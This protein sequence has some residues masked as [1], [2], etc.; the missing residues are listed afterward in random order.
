MVEEDIE[1]IEREKDKK[2]RKER[3]REDG[4]EVHVGE[5]KGQEGD[6][7]ALQRKRGLLH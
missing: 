2:I 1:V 6:T 5:E 4:K 7:E 3:T